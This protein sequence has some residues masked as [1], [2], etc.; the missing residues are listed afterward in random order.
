MELPVSSFPRK[1]G[2]PPGREKGLEA[3][4][5]AIRELADMLTPAAA[6]RRQDGDAS[7]P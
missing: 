2:R 4:D 7:R 3:R 6:E 1:R 5:A